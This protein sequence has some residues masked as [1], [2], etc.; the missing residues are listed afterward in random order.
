MKDDPRGHEREIVAI[1]AR[2]DETRATLSCGHIAR[3]NQIYVYRIGD[4]CRCLKCREEA[5]P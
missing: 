2:T 3:L 4:R 1:E 5:R